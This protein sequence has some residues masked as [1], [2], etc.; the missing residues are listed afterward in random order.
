MLKL[1]ILVGLAV[2]GYFILKNV[3]DDT[4]PADTYLNYN[5]NVPP[6]P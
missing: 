3:L 5:P 1:L 6:R 4:K 2:A